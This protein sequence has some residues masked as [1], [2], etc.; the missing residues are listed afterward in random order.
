MNTKSK[1]SVIPADPTLP[2]HTGVLFVQGLPEDTKA[3]F[4]AACAR[5]GTTMRDV[6]IELMRHYAEKTNN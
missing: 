1:I 6:I 3:A 2:R 5:R 4:K